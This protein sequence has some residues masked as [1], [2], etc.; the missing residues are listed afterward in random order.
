MN[1][2]PSFFCLSFTTFYSLVVDMVTTTALQWLKHAWSPSTSRRHS[3]KRHKQQHPF[4]ILPE[5]LTLEIFVHLDSLSLY[6][7]TQTSMRYRHMISRC[8]HLWTWLWF[9][10]NLPLDC[11]DLYRM[12]CFLVEHDGLHEHILSARFDRCTIDSTTLER[13]LRYLPRLSTLSVVGCPNLDCFQFL[14]ILRHT[15]APM[16]PMNYSLPP[17]RLLSS[18]PLLQHLT[19]LEIRG[20]FPSERGVM[21]YAHEIYCYTSIRRLLAKNNNAAR[22]RAHRI[23]RRRH[24]RARVLE[25]EDEVI[26]DDDE[27]E[28]E[29]ED[30]EDDLL[31]YHQFWL[32][33][34]QPLF[35]ASPELLV[36]PSTAATF[37]ALSSI[38][39]SAIT[40]TTTSTV[41]SNKNGRHVGSNSNRRKSIEMDVQPCSH[42]HR[43]VTQP[44]P[45]SC[46]ACGDP[47]LTPC[48]QCMCYHCRRILCRSCFRLRRG[49]RVLRCQ[50]CQLARRVCENTECITSLHHQNSQSN[51]PRR[52]WR[53]RRHD[54]DND[55]MSGF[56]CAWCIQKK[57]P[58][59][60]L[61]WIRRLLSNKQSSSSSTIFNNR[62]PLYLS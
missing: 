1:L 29:E 57:N 44:T 56:H 48:A 46:T 30:E 38:T 11:H 27:E 55:V 42:C 7:V 53:R 24:F 35:R 8:I 14:S 4:D 2:V 18:G 40:T 10:P 50:K 5:E 32:L 33:L 21:S 31:L 20:L 17:S 6:R 54:S 52:P 26:L 22:Q 13:V 36:L 15:T 51:K 12:L 39:H 47:T 25:E 23:S 61:P 34:Q 3:K 49:W 60:R 37:S 9:D 28:D 45:A 58:R 41:N 16:G 59:Q 62:P 43:N 19:R